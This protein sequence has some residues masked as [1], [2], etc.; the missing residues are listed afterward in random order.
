MHYILGKTFSELGR[1][2]KGNWSLTAAEYTQQAVDVAAWFLDQSTLGGDGTRTWWLTMNGVT[3]PGSAHQA[4]GT[5]GLR[6]EGYSLYCNY[7]IHFFHLE[8]FEH[9]ASASRMAEYTKQWIGGSNSVY[10]P[11]NYT[12]MKKYSDGTGSNVGYRLRSSAILAAYDSTGY[13]EQAASDVVSSP[14]NH[15]IYGGGGVDGLHYNGSM[16]MALIDAQDSG[17]CAGEVT[18]QSTLGFTVQIQQGG[19]NPVGIVDQR[20]TQVSIA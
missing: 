3:P 9:F 6:T 10:T 15:L 20:P 16:H 13:L 7:W 2:P 11:G 4:E 5:S 1:T 14:T 12:N 19:L 8:G 17:L 18:D